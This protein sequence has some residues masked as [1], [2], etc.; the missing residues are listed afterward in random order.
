LGFTGAPPLKKKTKQPLGIETFIVDSIM[1]EMNITKF[2]CP[3]ASVFEERRKSSLAHEMKTVFTS[4]N[5]L[6]LMGLSE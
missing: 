4:R 1:H 6:Y 3:S 5:Q 2:T